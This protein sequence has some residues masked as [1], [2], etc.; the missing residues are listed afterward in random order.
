MCTFNLTGLNFFSVC[1]TGHANF[2]ESFF[3][4]TGHI[5]VAFQVLRD[6]HF[7]PYGANK[8]VDVETLRGS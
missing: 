3:C 8:S 7:K 4:L 1:L 5:V 6:F 2:C